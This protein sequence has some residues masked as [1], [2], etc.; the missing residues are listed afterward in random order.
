MTT[1]GRILEFTGDL[2]FAGLA[3]TIALFLWFVWTDRFLGPSRR[4]GL[5]NNLVRA[6]TTI[7]PIVAFFLCLFAVGASDDFW[8]VART[9]PSWGLY[10]AAFCSL[11]LAGLVAVV[12]WQVREHRRT[13]D[14]LDP[15][16]NALN[17]SRRNSR[18]FLFGLGAWVVL[19]AVGL[20]WLWLINR[21]T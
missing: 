4:Y 17:Q 19:F 8:V 6:T 9:Y 21:G 14:I 1:A 7:G 16:T 10:Y 12:F 20:A 15:D 11:T 13:M 18:T 3:G 2:L 5:R